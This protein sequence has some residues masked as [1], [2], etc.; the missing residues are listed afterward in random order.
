MHMRPAPNIRRGTHILE[1]P[2][3][4]IFD[5][6]SDILTDVTI[7]RTDGQSDVMRRRH[8]DRLRSGGIAATILVVWIDPP[9]TDDPT[10]RM[11]QILGAASDEVADMHDIA[12]L[13]SHPGD[14]QTIQ[15]SGRLAVILGMEGLS[16]LRGNVS[17]ISTLY[18]LGVRHAS[19]TW[20]EENEFATGAGHPDSSRGLTRS[21]IEALAK[22][23]SLGM[24][25]D[26]SHA[27]EKT[28]TDIC[29]H[30]T[31]PFI[32]SHS[33]AWE[34][35]NVAR[36]L[37]DYQIKAIAE[38]GGVIGMNAW[39]DFIHPTEPTAENLARHVDH[40][41]ELVGT[42]HIGLGFDFVD[43]LDPDTMSSLVP[44]SRN[45]AIG[46][47]DASKAGELCRILLRKGYSAADV[48]K[49][50]YGNMA[51]IVEEIL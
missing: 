28:F 37:K 38:C 18:R 33:N 50:A 16:G 24:I 22:M 3:M 49:I 23:E 35:R 17:L 27:N 51:R 21:G 19:L 47:E 10:W 12:G 43:F 45:A 34:L 39:P 44:G 8:I 2:T 30:A 15:D 26:V 11:L 6:H 32:A 9:H 41:A 46:L 29:E 25:V 31:K 48:E 1:E 14:L 5:A 4:R 36:N 42:D 40:I 20:N 7:R 13:V